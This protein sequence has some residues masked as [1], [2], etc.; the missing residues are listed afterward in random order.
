M[1]KIFT[2]VGGL[3]LAGAVSANAE[4]ISLYFYDENN[5]V[6][7]D[8]QVT[9]IS[10]DEDGNFVISDFLYCEA[11]LCFNFQVPAVGDYSDISFTG[12]IDDSEGFPYIM[13]AEGEYP[14]CWLQNVPGTEKEWTPIYWPYVAD[15]GY[16][17]VSRYDLT[18]PKNEGYKEYEGCIFVS[19]TDSENDYFPW[20][21]V[22]FDFDMP[23]PNRVESLS[24]ASDGKVEF[25][26]LNGHR[27][28]NPTDGI[29]IR[30]QGNKTSKVFLH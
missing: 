4:A 21:A 11:P 17:Y 14:T 16:S 25:F 29:F 6:F 1:K 18:D 9:E 24:G 22:Y 13:N 30:R 28:D 23:E 3:L 5:N 15:K 20:V 12:F 19:G 27:I 8:P 10:M 26:D 7:G 2:I